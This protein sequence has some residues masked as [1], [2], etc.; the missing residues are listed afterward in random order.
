MCCIHN[1]R[2]DSLNT[3]SRLARAN[4]PV[5]RLHVRSCQITRSGASLFPRQLNY[6]TSLF[7]SLACW[8]ISRRHHLCRTLRPELFYDQ[9]CH[10]SA[11][12]STARRVLHTWTSGPDPG[13][14]CGGGQSH[15]INVLELAVCLGNWISR[16]CSRGSD[17]L[18]LEEG[19]LLVLE[20]IVRWCWRE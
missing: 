12:S 14:V 5:I 1:S 3:G 6:S 13:L 7:P 9:I 16:D 8:E 4:V 20:G 2:L 19:S 15:E 18:V 10:T 11:G 17:L